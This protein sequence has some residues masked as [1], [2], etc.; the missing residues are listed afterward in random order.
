MREIYREIDR[1]NNAQFKVQ[2]ILLPD[3]SD[4]TKG[5]GKLY[6]FTLN[7]PKSYKIPGFKPT[8]S[9]VVVGDSFI[10]LSGSEPNPILEAILSRVKLDMYKHGAPSRKGRVSIHAMNEQYIAWGTEFLEK[11]RARGSY[12]YLNMELSI[13]PA[14]W[15]QTPVKQSEEI[16]VRRSVGSNAAGHRLP[17]SRD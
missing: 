2:S 13:N 10:Q 4:C 9:D 12:M 14:D 5:E 8:L 16:T 3:I 1:Y 11:I 15:G 17:T 6:V 7:N